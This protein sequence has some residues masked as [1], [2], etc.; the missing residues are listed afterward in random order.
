M[1][2][3]SKFIL[4]QTLVIFILGL[5]PTLSWGKSYLKEIL[6]AFLLS[7]GNML[8]GYYLVMN[9]FE[10]KN[11]EFYKTVYGGMLLRMLFLFSFSIFVI[12]NGY[13]QSTPYMLSLIIFYVIHQWT[14]ISFWLKNLKGR[15][16]EI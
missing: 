6:I 10:K 5:F 9:T 14:E 15:P 2:N 1:K 11:S 12:N 3:F 16:V 8:S 13:L 4:L 7:L